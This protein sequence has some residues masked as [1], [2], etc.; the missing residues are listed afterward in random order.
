MQRTLW[1][2]VCAAGWSAAVRGATPL[3][4]WR[5][6]RRSW[7]EP[8]YAQHWGERWGYGAHGGSGPRPIWIHAVSLGETQ[9]CIPLIQALVARD[10]SACFLL[11]HMTATGRA[12]GAQI[13]SRLALPGRI[14]QVWLPYD[15]PGAVKRF[16]AGHQPAVGLLMETEVW[17]NLVAA[18]SAA[19]IPLGLVSARLS[20]RSL[21][22][23][24]RVRAL[25]GPALQSLQFVLPQT[26]RDAARLRALE[27][28][29]TAVTGNLKFD[30]EADASAQR[31]GQAWRAALTGRAVLLAASTRDGEEDA[32]LD[33][34]AGVSL[35]SAPGR[36]VVGRA[37]PLLVIVPRHP[38]RFE[39]VAKRIASRGL[40]VAR[41]SL[42]DG[43]EQLRQWGLCDV[44]VGD[45]M[46][47]MAAWYAMADVAILGGSLRPF[48]G[49]NLI[50]AAA[51]GCPIL[52]GPHTFNF[53]QATDDAVAMGAAN[54]V[55]DA[56]DAIAQGLAICA[57]AVLR[58]QMADAAVRWVAEHRGAAQRTVRALEP[59]LPTP[60]PRRHSRS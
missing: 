14:E 21:A 54:R 27:C 51:Q 24:R 59:W 1:Q 13:A 12:A 52:A 57:D 4:L 7:R 28:P 47:E 36:A 43:A 55:A 58:Q 32:L 35:R 44:L 9:A 20:E 26:Q 6:W 39:E 3:L 56:A 41:R 53:A 42:G 38:Q 48:G 49:Q 34:L 10:P 23:A 29:I 37:K 5:L 60:H 50:E 46:G 25:I 30:R 22:R 17:P 15:T 19:R 16:V 11:T 8:G 2:H 31:Q 40:Q 33:A 18:C 45:S